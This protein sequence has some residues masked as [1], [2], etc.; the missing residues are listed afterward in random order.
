[1]ENQENQN[2]QAGDTFVGIVKLLAGLMLLYVGI[3][4]MF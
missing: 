3:K 4:A 2:Q 1:M